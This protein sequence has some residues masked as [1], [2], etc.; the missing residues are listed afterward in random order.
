MSTFMPT[1]FTNQARDTKAK[2]DEFFCI[3]ARGEALRIIEKMRS[4]AHSGEHLT[5]LSDQQDELLV[6]LGTIPQYTEKHY[7][8]NAAGERRAKGLITDFS[9]DG[10]DEIEDA[11]D[12]YEDYAYMLRSIDEIDR[13]IDAEFLKKLN[14]IYG[15][16]KSSADHMTRLVRRLLRY[17]FNVTDESIAGLTTRVLILK[18]FINQFGYDCKGIRCEELE[19][20]VAKKYNG[21]VD[22]IDDSI[23]DL[24]SQPQDIKSDDK[25]GVLFGDK[26]IGELTKLHG[27]IRIKAPMTY[28]TK[29]ICERLCRVMRA[30]VLSEAAV[31]GTAVLL[32]DCFADSLPYYEIGI[33]HIRNYSS[34]ESIDA[35]EE[36][37]EMLRQRHSRGY[38]LYTDFSYSLRLYTLL[39]FFGDK[40]QVLRKKSN[41]DLIK[42]LQPEAFLKVEK[43]KGQKC[44]L[45]SVF[46]P[47]K[48]K[49]ADFES[50]ED[51]EKYIKLVN[52]L[53]KV[54]FDLCESTEAKKAEKINYAAKIGKAYEEQTERALGEP[55]TYVN[56]PDIYRLMVLAKYYAQV[57]PVTSENIALLQD[58]CPGVKISWVPGAKFF[59]DIVND[60]VVDKIL[61]ATGKV[62]KNDNNSLKQFIA[63][64]ERFVEDKE[65]YTQ[66]L[67][68][69][70]RS[71]YNTASKKGGED[72]K[73]NREVLYSSCAR[74]F[75]DY[76]LLEI[77]DSLANA[78]FSSQGKTREYLYIFAVA[79]DIRSVEN[80]NPLRICDIEKNLF[81]D[82]YTDN[83]VNRL[84]LVA[85]LG[86][87]ED[88]SV[89]GYGINYK[90]FA[91]VT[92]LWCLEQ[93]ELTPKQRLEK[94]YEIIAYCKKYG[95]TQDDFS[96]SIRDEQDY[97][98][99]RYKEGFAGTMSL[100]E[101]KFKSY[102]T[103]NY[104]CKSNDSGIMQ[105]NDE[106]R[107]AARVI[108]EQEAVVNSLLYK[109]VKVKELSDVT[110]DKL[111]L[112]LMSY[113]LEDFF[114]E[115][116]YLTSR[117]CRNCPKHST[118]IFPYCKE[119]FEPFETN[120]D[121]EDGLGKIVFENCRDCFEY[122]G[123]TAKEKEQL[124]A[125]FMRLKGR[126]FDTPKERF[127]ASFSRVND[128][129]TE[130]YAS[131]KLL[132][133]RIQKRLTV[134]M[135]E[136]IRFKNV[137]RST[138]MA[139]CFYQ[140]V[141]INWLKRSADEETYFGNFE[142]FYDVFVNGD[143]FNVEL[144]DMDYSYD[145]CSELPMSETI[146]YKGADKMLEEAG[147]APVNSKNIFD[148][149]V[150]YIAYRDNFLP[151]YTDPVDSFVD[152]YQKLYDQFEKT[153][154][155]IGEK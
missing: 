66:R 127:E 1:D 19:D 140:F 31:N 25:E 97:I 122:F 105:I 68:K 12:T 110:T 78:E 23:F 134:E 92:F 90:N 16:Y 101:E 72:F 26:Y 96:G 55:I 76:T 114:Y 148:I 155:E 51:K 128:L 67:Y 40:I 135:G 153:E 14:E 15:E 82:Y 116:H 131:L 144:D 24:I 56:Y 63:Y 2:L 73:D 154:R 111:E 120:L 107:T 141:L 61:H 139:V 59:S 54:L 102:L 29:E 145:E 74:E 43:N 81:W 151:L 80:G 132:L 103:K 75:N 121:S 118:D 6:L 117:R 4:T 58:V 44:K 49:Y 53:E 126:Q 20:V 27:T 47:E 112:A 108:R 35:V 88:T 65:K 69:R 28:V 70:V 39:K 98:T 7:I 91:E 21:D 93:P 22:K 71:R 32:S 33:K 83:I 42:N 124:K 8:E 89:D 149:Y 109:V 137:S 60:S 84:P 130:S 36:L 18:Q 85:G 46:S 104:P 123:Q 150:I 125:K 57:I 37:N 95:K 52:S 3:I 30:D 10:I 38:Y 64:A 13:T 142:K 152:Q 11:L 119:Y 147:Y 133:N 34:L 106:Q 50:S 87:S 62:L 94:A 5:K 143:I 86:D 45:S 138:V 77:A 99:K 17:N 113:E 79:F 129:C 115:Y 146:S 48:I 9:S 100:T 41:E 136:E